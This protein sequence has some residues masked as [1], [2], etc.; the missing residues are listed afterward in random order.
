[1]ATNAQDLIAMAND[2]AP[3]LNWTDA[4][5][6]NFKTEPNSTTLVANTQYQGTAMGLVS[7]EDGMFSASVMSGASYEHAVI[8]V[9]TKHTD[10]KRAI[11]EALR[12]AMY[13]RPHRLK[14]GPPEEQPKSVRQRKL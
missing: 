10:V 8:W 9:G 6:L 12:L 5:G 14:D 3:F 1:M 2:A 13:T 7:H 4:S 11:Y